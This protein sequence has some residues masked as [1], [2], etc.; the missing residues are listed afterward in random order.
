MSSYDT[1]KTTPPDLSGPCERC[2]NGDTCMLCLDHPD[3]CEC[4]ER[5]I[6]GVDCKPD[7][8]IC[9]ECDGTGY[10]ED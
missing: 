3:K 2:D 1:W 6:N 9:Q 4:E 10:I 8:D 5:V 7:L